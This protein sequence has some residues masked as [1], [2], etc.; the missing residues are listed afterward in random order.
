MTADHGEG[1]TMGDETTLLFVYGTL[2]PML[3][4]GEHARLVHDL[5]IVGAATVPGVLLD[6]GDYPGLVAGA[7]LVH[8]DLLRVTDP[9][10]LA[11]LDAY[12]ECDGPEPLFR[13]E[14]IS[15]HLS[16][17]T[18]VEAW[19]YRYAR[20]PRGLVIAGGDYA[21]HVASR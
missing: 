7:G 10:T 5:E 2:R 4:A 18:D 3:A 6:L 1:R 20:S 14:R 15:A 17:G 12:E 8:G 19:A 9:A 21:A 11:A 16:D 13:R